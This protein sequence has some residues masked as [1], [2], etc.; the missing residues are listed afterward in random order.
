[1]SWEHSAIVPE[2]VE[3]GTLEIIKDFWILTLSGR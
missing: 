1:M 2:L 3:L